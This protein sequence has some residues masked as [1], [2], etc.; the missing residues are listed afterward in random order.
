MG[1]IIINC[2]DLR[3]IFVNYND[4]VTK[5]YNN[6]NIIR[7]EA[8]N[9]YDKDVFAYLLDDNIK[10]FIS[11][12]N[13]IENSEI[14]NLINNYDI[15][16]K[17]EKYI[18]KRDIEIFDKIDFEKIDDNFIEN[19]TKCNFEEKFEKKLDRYLLKLCSKINKIFDFNIILKLM[20][21]FGTSHFL[22]PTPIFP[23]LLWYYYGTKK[24][25]LNF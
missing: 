16:Y 8:N 10:K 14:I 20:S 13:D 21:K 12:K 24:F 25:S 11:E 7:K 1:I 5:L 18:N 4:L 19:F 17:D 23:I 22:V 15:F 6:D 3:A 9:F 2:Y